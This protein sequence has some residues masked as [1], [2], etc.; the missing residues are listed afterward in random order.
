MD[1]KQQPE[2]EDIID[3][4]ENNF[5]EFKCSNEA[6]LHAAEDII[7]LFKPVPTSEAPDKIPSATDAL[8]AH[9]K[10]RS[11]INGSSIPDDDKILDLLKDE[12]V[13]AVIKMLESFALL[14]EQRAVE[15]ERKK[16]EAEKKNY[17]PLLTCN[18]CGDYYGVNINHQCYKCLQ[19]L[20]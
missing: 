2:V 10:S 4:I 3:I 8:I 6:V 9:A 1:N 5:K 19:P 11:I 17:K 18:N 16:W 7:E 20:F 13:I 14:R 15:V 12:E